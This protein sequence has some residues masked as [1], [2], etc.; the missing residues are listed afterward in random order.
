MLNQTD[1]QAIYQDCNPSERKEKLK[2]TA[3]KI[4]HKEYPI[5]MDEVMVAAKEKALSS[6]ANEMLD[7]EEAKKI[8]TDNLK[9]LRTEFE[10]ISRDLKYKKIFQMGDVFEFVD[11]EAKLV[12]IY[13]KEGILRETR[14]AT[15]SELQN[16][17]LKFDDAKEAKN[18]Q[19]KNILGIVTIQNAIQNKI[20]AEV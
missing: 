19:S 4:Y 5:E 13:C 2:N 7:A 10:N 8:A 15:N 18:Q 3:D 11:A 12:R 9:S 17:K 20:D 6:V 1:K 14:A 16:I